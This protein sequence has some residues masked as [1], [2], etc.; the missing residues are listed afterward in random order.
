ML[1]QLPLKL[2]NL[3]S[4]LRANNWRLMVVSTFQ[5][6]IA[7]STTAIWTRSKHP[8]SQSERNWTPTMPIRNSFSGVMNTDN[9]SEVATL[10]TIVNKEFGV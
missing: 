9:H 4:H 10:T 6:R 8:I 1:P 3:K 2:P 5:M 7:H